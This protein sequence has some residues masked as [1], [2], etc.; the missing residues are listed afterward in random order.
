MRKVLSVLLCFVLCAC[1]PSFAAA[2]VWQ[3]QQLQQSL[4]PSYSDWN[5][6]PSMGTPAAAMTRTSGYASIATNTSATFT[7][8]GYFSTIATIG[9]HTNAQSTDGNWVNMA[10]TTS[11]NA[12]AYIYNNV[13]FQF[14][15]NV[16]FITTIK[17]GANAADIQACNIWIG[18][19]STSDTLQ[20]PS[21]TSFTRC[22]FRYC[23]PTADTTAF[24]RCV[25]C[26][27][28]TQNVIVTTSPIASNTQYTL[29]IDCSTPG[30][31]YFYVNGVQVASTTA[32]LPAGSSQMFG[33]VLIQNQGAGTARNLKVKDVWED[34]I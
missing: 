5:I 6:M 29:A 13:N 26:D 2:N 12:N 4:T 30:T 3:V 33:Y 8:T 17:T 14:R 7:N 19:A 32:N 28:T 18:F 11:A 31:V 25:T 1:T 15:Q 10:T 22:I 23:P 21:S 9:S 34:V 24:W 27:A 16:R 20:T